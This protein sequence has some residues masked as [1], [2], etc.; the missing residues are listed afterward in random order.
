MEPFSNADVVH[1]NSITQTI[2]TNAGFDGDI[3]PEFHD[4]D[5]GAAAFGVDVAFGLAGHVSMHPVPEPG[6]S[7]MLL[8]G[9]GALAYMRRRTVR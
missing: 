4:Y 1:G 6:S 3:Y 2:D 7:V 8:S 9:I 5:S